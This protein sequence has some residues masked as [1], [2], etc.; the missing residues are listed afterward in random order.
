MLAI[1]GGLAAAAFWTVTTLSS[2]RAS[3]LIGPWSTLA[4]VMIS[5]FVVTAPAAAIVGVPADSSRD[6]AAWLAL[7]GVCNVGGLLF[8]YE[9]LRIGKVGLASPIISTEGAVA[10]VI[11][12]AA[13][14][15]LGL[16][17][18]AALAV[19][20]VGI[21]AVAAGSGGEDHRGHHDFRAA[22]L[23]G[24]AALSFGL[25]LYSAGRV[26][27]EVPL[28]WVV[29]PP[30]LIGVALIAIPLALA[31]RVRLTRQAAPYVIAAGLGEVGGYFAF[32]FGARHGIAVTAV[33]GSQFAVT[34]ALAAFILFGERL[35]RLRVAG[36]V[37]TA[38]GVAVLSALQ[39]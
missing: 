35:G 8:A 24:A 12:I 34:S 20:A 19:I 9:A 30:R 37:V 4:W 28:I 17:R 1:F 15:A 25:G 33:L 26:S 14:E 10:A 18:G 21:V 29:F 13:G 11:A 38:L 39:A 5:G 2:S 36:V 32:A 23:A 22:L 31:A 27:N 16:P 3:R 7:A 6:V